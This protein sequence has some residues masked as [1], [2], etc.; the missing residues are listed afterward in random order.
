MITLSLAQ[1]IVIVQWF[2]GFMGA[3]LIFSTVS[4]LKTELQNSSETEIR[5]VETTPVIQAPHPLKDLKA[6]N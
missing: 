5:I 4:T 2:L 6:P 3:W 1:K